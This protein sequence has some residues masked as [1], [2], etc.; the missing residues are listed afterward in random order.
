MALNPE[1]HRNRHLTLHRC[2]DELFADF[3]T[4]TKG[5]LD[6]PISDLV[7]WSHQQ[8]LEPDHDEPGGC[9]EDPV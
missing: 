2:F 7:A 9:G 1:Q 6:S 8:T 5:G 3:I 4:H